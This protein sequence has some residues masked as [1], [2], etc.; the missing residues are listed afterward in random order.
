MDSTHFVGLHK[1]TYSKEYFA[2]YY[3]VCC[4]GWKYMG[5]KTYFWWWETKQCV[6]ECKSK[7]AMKSLGKMETE[8]STHS[9]KKHHTIENMDLNEVSC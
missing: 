5:E 7:E 2:T 3:S 8:K 1:N 6:C 9:K 4:L